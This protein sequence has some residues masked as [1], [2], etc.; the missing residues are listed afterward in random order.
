MSRFIL[1]ALRG[2]ALIRLGY[3][4][5][6]TQLPQNPPV[7]V[8]DRCRRGLH[9][10]NVSNRSKSKRLWQ[11]GR[12]AT[13]KDVARHAGVAIST[14]SA[15]INRSAPVSEEVLAKVQAA[16]RDIGYVPHGGARSLRMGQSRLI[17]L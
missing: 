7:R 16:V 14:A 4:N 6:S 1:P 13:I 15:A 9:T 8:F 5:V 12:V 10:R 2:S 3:R 11:E 17:G